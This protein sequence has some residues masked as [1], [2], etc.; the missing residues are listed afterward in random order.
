M[1]NKK[2]TAFFAL[3]IILILGFGIGFL[4][5]DHFGTV[6]RL[7]SDERTILYAGESS[8]VRASLV[9]GMREEPYL[10][11]GKKATMVPFGIVRMLF[12]L[13]IGQT[14]F[15]AIITI[16]GEDKELLLEKSP[17]ENAFYADIEQIVSLQEPIVVSFDLASLADKQ[18]SLAPVSHD[19]EIDSKKAMQIAVRQL[20]E[21]NAF[22]F[23][24]LGINILG[25]PSKELECRLQII[26]SDMPLLQNHFWHFSILSKSNE[27]FA[28]VIDPHSGQILA[29]S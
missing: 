25:T 10:Q 12:S 24:F 9:C 5:Q 6:Q 16:H 11:D 21:Q 19:W 15:P 22:G 28:C 29:Q 27:L 13:Q 7:V 1:K 14:S 23:Q 17:Y 26:S 8:K 2:R 4:N 18:V 3:A 20:K